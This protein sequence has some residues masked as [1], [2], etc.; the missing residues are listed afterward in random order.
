VQ[1]SASSSAELL[2][3]GNDMVATPYRLIVQVTVGFDVGSAFRLVH[4]VRFQFHMT[5]K[6]KKIDTKIRWNQN[7]MLPEQNL[8]SS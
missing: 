4:L 6:H 3:Q 8:E 5:P 7:E 2:F 1:D